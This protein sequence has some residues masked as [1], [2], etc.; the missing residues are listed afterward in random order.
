M[1]SI[2]ENK[3]EFNYSKSQVNSPFSSE[4]VL[5]DDV[6]FTLIIQPAFKNSYLRMH[7]IL[8]DDRL[9]VD[10]HHLKLRLVPKT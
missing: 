6:T 3:I 10:L 2:E 4:F 9:F 1:D 5:G 7:R 8:F